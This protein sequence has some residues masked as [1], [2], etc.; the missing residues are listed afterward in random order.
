[1]AQ[2]VSNNPDANNTS[3]NKWGFILSHIQYGLIDF[4]QMK[5]D[6]QAKKKPIVESVYD[7]FKAI[8]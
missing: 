5:M 1:M 8:W 6:P 4:A 7:K 3:R 2:L